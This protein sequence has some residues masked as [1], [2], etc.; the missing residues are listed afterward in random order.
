MCMV[1]TF[2]ASML[3][4]YLDLDVALVGDVDKG[5]FADV[6]DDPD[7]IIM[8]CKQYMF[9]TH[10]AQKPLLICPASFSAKLH[11]D[12]PQSSHAIQ[13]WFVVYYLSSHVIQVWF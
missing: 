9:H 2:A 6:R 3:L 12:G 4:L 8:L 10:L 11:P 13:V 7:D 1:Q 5:C